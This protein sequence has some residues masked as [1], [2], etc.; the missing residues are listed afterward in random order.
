MRSFIQII[1]AT[2]SKLF[3]PGPEIKKKEEKRVEKEKEEKDEVEKEEEEM[4]RVY[5]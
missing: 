3:I 1:L 5:Y 2:F 4:K